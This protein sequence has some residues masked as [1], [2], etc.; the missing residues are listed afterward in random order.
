MEPQLHQEELRDRLATFKDVDCNEEAVLTVSE[1][2]Q[3]GIQF[4][5][6]GQFLAAIDEFQKAINDGA[7]RELWNDWATAHLACGELAQAEQGY[8]RALEL[9]GQYSPAAVN[10]ALLLLQLRRPQEALPYLSSLMRAARDAEESQ[11]Q[12]LSAAAEAIKRA[13][14][15]IYL[16]SVEKFFNALNRLPTVDP[17]W[18]EHLKAAQAERAFDSNFQVQEGLRLLRELP[19]EVR[20]LA[21]EALTAKAATHP[22]CGLLAGVYYLE[23]GEPQTALPLLRAASLA[24]ERDLY[25]ENRMI[26]AEVTVADAQGLRHPT[27]SGL[28]EYL[29]ESFCERPWTCLDLNGFS[30][31]E[32]AKISVCDA[33]SPV[34][35]GN[36]NRTPINEIWNSEM[37]Q[38]FRKSILDGSFRYCSKVRCPKIAHRKLPP[39][40]AAL[41]GTKPLAGGVGATQETL[42]TS[43]DAGAPWGLIH[44]AGPVNVLIGA[45]R[46]CNLACPKCR[47]DFYR[48]DEQRQQELNRMLDGFS[49]ELWRGVRNMR[50]NTAGEVFVSQPCRRLL[51]KLSREHFPD[52][53]FDLITNGQL[54][55]RETFEEFDLRARMSGLSISMDAATEATYRI[56]RRGGDF[57]RLL[58]NLAFLDGLRRNEGEKFIWCLEFVVSARNFREM[59]DFVRLAKRYGADQVLFTAFFNWH[60]TAEEFARIN[61]ADPCHPWHGEFLEILRAPE[62]NDPMVAVSGLLHLRSQGA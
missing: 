55:N 40:S 10:L 37:A 59:P 22:G 56:C 12:L 6:A 50:M 25:A 48:A 5:E 26:D 51:K 60:Y 53:R 27:F 58:S 44:N 21:V 47:K 11:Q 31:E 17:A 13:A 15:P 35:I 52:L 2:H 19:E 39:K 30:F 62:I 34:C 9:D 14:E 41:R 46:T 36:A 49:T 8:R 20:A 18:P 54:F 32:G 4:F 7:D 61:V 57:A 1:H 24:R 23:H 3:G 33:W 28:R 42:Q 16:L 45:D 29:A 43:S 38:E